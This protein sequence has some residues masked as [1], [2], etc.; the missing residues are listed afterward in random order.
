MSLRYIECLPLK[1]ACQELG[2]GRTSFYN[3]HKK[4]L[5][6]VVSILWAEYQRRRTQEQESS[7][8]SLAEEEA[9]RIARSAQRQPVSL[10]DLLQSIRSLVMELAQA[11]GLILNIDAPPILPMGYGDPA[12]LRQ[13][14]LNMLTE[15]FK[16]T[17]GES[18]AL[19]VRLE[20]EETIWRLKGLEP[21]K[22]AEALEQAPGLAIGRKLLHVYGGKLYSEKLSSKETILVATI[23]AIKPKTVLLID[24]D[25]KALELYKRYLP[26]QEYDL[27][28][29]QSA[30]EAWTLLAKRRPD[31]IVLDVLMPQEDGWD[32][33]QRLKTFPETKAIPVIVCSVLQQPRLALMLGASIVLQKPILQEDL[34]RAIRHV[35][36]QE[37][38]PAGRHLTAP[39][40]TSSPYSGLSDDSNAP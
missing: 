17:K 36:A 19:E 22:V 12:L 15:G 10:G 33:L 6:A 26:S 25:P 34:E 20:G 29:A 7:S 24:D 8:E 21:A 2:L 3:Y 16:C 30:Q 32:I 14:I 1:D 40:D 39:V 23:P 35:L 37:D 11:Q 5:A 31:V 18:L 38:S 28:I 4:G 13:A 27:Q 9:V